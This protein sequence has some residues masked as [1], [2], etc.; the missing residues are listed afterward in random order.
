MPFHDILTQLVLGRLAM[1]TL[2]QW[3]LLHQQYDPHQPGL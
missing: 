2:H 3:P 1:G